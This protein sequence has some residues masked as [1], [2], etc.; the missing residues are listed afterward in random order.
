MAWVNTVITPVESI[1]R[2]FN[3]YFGADF[4]IGSESTDKQVVRNWVRKVV[5]DPNAMWG[6][7]GDIEDDDRP[8]TRAIRRGA[9]SGRKEVIGADA[10]KHKL[11]IDR[12]VLPVLLPLVKKPCIGVLGGHHWYD[13]GEQT[14]TQYICNALTGEKGHKVP[15][16]GQM[17][18]WVRMIFRGEPRWGV[19]KLMHIQHGVGG[20]GTLASA[21]NRLE[22]TAQGFHGDIYVRAHDCKL[23]SGKYDILE[24]VRTQDDCP[25]R[26]KHR[27]VALMNIGSATRG[28]EMTLNDPNYAEMGMMRPQTL[29]WGVVHIQVYKQSRTVDPHKSVTA[30]VTIEI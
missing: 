25:P 6:L 8:T 19:E 13:M 26:L 20:G 4:Q 2:K 7:L 1:P 15:Y 18:A 29:G 28:Y 11:W 3:I 24:P 17:S 22:K 21:L 14:S 27:T 23:V 10:K 9:F 12:E 30:D 5:A 16:L